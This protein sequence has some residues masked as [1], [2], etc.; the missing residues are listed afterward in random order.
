[1]TLRVKFRPVAVAAATALVAAF[2]LVFAA[3]AA[4][5]EV[6]AEQAPAAVDACPSGHFCFW[7]GQHYTGSMATMSTGSS[8]GNCVTAAQLGLSAIRSAQKGGTA[9]QFQAA[10]YANNSCGQATDPR[11]VEDNTPTID[12]PAL[13]V[14]QILIP[15]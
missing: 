4:L 12:P 9:C 3:P 6:R 14:Q 2:A 5:A 1:M 13:S 15:C 7:S 8:W 11:W 10:L